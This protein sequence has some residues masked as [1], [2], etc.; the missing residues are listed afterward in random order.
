MVA[1]CSKTYVL[2]DAKGEKKTAL[3]GINKSFVQNAL[4]TSQKVL[5]TGIPSTSTNKSFR[6]HN[7][8]IFT[9]EHAKTG[10]SQFYCKRELVDNIDT[11]PIDLALSP[12]PSKEAFSFDEKHIL[13]PV[14]DQS[15]PCI[16]EDLLTLENCTISEREEIAIAYIQERRLHDY[17]FDQALQALKDFKFVFVHKDYP[18]ANMW[19]YCLNKTVKSCR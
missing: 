8:T 3:K 9:Y 18:G 11:K 7:N 10:F 2:K 19:G 4:A 6:V 15:H 5:E 12:W 1:L 16:F 13:S 14:S 17:D